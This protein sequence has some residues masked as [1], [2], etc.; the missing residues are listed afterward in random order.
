MAHTRASMRPESATH[1]GWPL[2]RAADDC[3]PLSTSATASAT[4]SC[5]IT[6]RRCARTAFTAGPGGTRGRNQT[7]LT[8][9][10]TRDLRERVITP[11]MLLQPHNAPLQIAFY[12]GQ[13]FPVEYR[14]DL[15]A[16]EHGS[17]NKSVRTGYE[18]IRVPLH[19]SDKPSGEYEDFLTGFVLAHGQAWGKTRRCG[20]APR[21]R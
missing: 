1:R 20:L 6:L 9:G 3:G 19:H 4:I 10:K 11:D 2:I 7:P 5:P 8:P 14:G 12:Q 21:R 17:W 18:V 13:Q 15:F 16:T